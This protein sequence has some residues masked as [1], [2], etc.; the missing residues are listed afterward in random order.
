MT[1]SKDWRQ[2]ELCI[3]IAHRGR[4]LQVDERPLMILDSLVRQL[5][6]YDGFILRRLVVPVQWEDIEFE[7]DT[8]I[9]SY[10]INSQNC[11]YEVL[12]AI[13]EAVDDSYVASSYELCLNCYTEKSTLL[14]SMDQ[15]P[16]AL[17]QEWIQEGRNPFFLIRLKDVAS[18]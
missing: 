15:K 6:L 17:H 11:C 13:L 14:L 2:Y 9:Y 7:L 1:P 4:Y 3:T 16:L 18:T 8:M 10:S 5:K 12:A